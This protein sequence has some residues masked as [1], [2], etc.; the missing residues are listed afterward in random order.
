M[1]TDTLTVPL[2]DTAPI[3]IDL[4]K[5]KRKAIKELKRGR[6]KLMDEVGQA[7]AEVRASLAEN[8]D[9]ARIVPV[10]LIYRQKKRRKGGLLPLSF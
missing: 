2:L 10:V 6:G 9:A 7:V 8:G 5:E 1:A 3:I 4:G